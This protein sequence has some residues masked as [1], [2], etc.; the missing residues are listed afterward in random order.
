[1]VRAHLTVLT[2]EKESTS[3]RE[4]KFSQ[5]R[6]IKHLEE[7][8]DK[9]KECLVWIWDE[10][11]FLTFFLVLHH[12]YKLNLQKLILHERISILDIKRTDGWTDGWTD[13]Y[14]LLDNRGRI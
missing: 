14:S 10:K 2:Y 11:H 6:D 9:E 7:K 13:A 8:H 4:G 12:I 5:V 3:I 1:M